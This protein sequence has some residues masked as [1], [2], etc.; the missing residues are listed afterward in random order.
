MKAISAQVVHLYCSFITI[1]VDLFIMVLSVGVAG[2]FKQISKILE[3]HR[4]MI[5]PECFW[6][7]KRQRFQ[8]LAELVDDV[9]DVLGNLILLSF[10][11]N[12]YFVC[13]KLLHSLE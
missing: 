8:E 12:L 13:V 3:L 1:F 5:M 2:K 7:H 9:D 6:T 10:S 4:G 11:T